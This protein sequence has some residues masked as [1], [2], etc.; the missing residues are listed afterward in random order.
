MTVQESIQNEKDLTSNS[1]L[2]DIFN[3]QINLPNKGSVARDHL[4]N[5]RTFLSWIRTSLVFVTFGIGFM[6]F[7]RLEEKSQCP[8]ISQPLRHPSSSSSSSS[9][10]LFNHNISGTVIAL[11][12]PIGGMCIILG[13]LTILFGIYRYF[14]VQ[15][16]LIKQEFPVTR[17]TVVVLLLINL[18][19]LILLLVLNFK[20]SL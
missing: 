8:Q 5:E 16:A 10:A 4:A 20:I 1:S 18:S 2:K 14:T 9:T 6:Q 17:L 3:F 13:I 11:C 12:R 7:Y 19:I 15:R